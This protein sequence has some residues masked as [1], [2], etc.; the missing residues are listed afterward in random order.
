MPH[1]LLREIL[2]LAGVDYLSDWRSSRKKLKKYSGT[3]LELGPCLIGDEPT[4]HVIH[5]RYLI[6]IKSA[7][8]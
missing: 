5:G 6:S 4:M 8:L 1:H 2:A 7:K 3:T